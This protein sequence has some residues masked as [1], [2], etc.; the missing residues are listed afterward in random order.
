MRSLRLPFVGNFTTS[1]FLIRSCLINDNHPLFPQNSSFE[2]PS[3]DHSLKSPS[4]CSQFTN[5]AHRLQ[6]QKKTSPSPGA[7]SSAHLSL[8]TGFVKIVKNKK[9]SEIFRILL[10]SMKEILRR[11]VG[12]NTFTSQRVATVTKMTMK[13]R[14]KQTFAAI[15]AATNPFLL[16]KSRSEHVC[17]ALQAS[18]ALQTFAAGG[19]RVAHCITGC[20]SRPFTCF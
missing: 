8:R 14:N 4:L 11:V 19:A 20:K 2:P 1:L 7:R 12:T 18:T 16:P 9:S 5:L 15:S 6:S 17:S 13:S 3:A 10:L